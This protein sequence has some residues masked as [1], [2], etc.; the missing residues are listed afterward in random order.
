M[1]LGTNKL[2]DRVRQQEVRERRQ[3]MLVCANTEVKRV[4]GEREGRRHGRQERVVIMVGEN[5]YGG[6]HSA[7]F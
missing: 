4:L 1:G 5:C 7:W 6:A 3:G 2:L